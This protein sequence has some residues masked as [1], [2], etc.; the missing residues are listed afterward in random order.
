MKKIFCPN[1]E[2]ETECEYRA[3]F[4]QRMFGNMWSVRTMTTKQAKKLLLELIQKEKQR[5][6]YD[7]SMARSYGAEYQQATRAQKRYAEMQELETYVKGME[8]EK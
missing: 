7:A 8:A 3:E 1:C 4:L 2:K 5:H 6:A